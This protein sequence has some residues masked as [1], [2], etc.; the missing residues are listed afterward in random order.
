MNDLFLTFKKQF[1]GTFQVV[2]WLRHR[3][4]KAGSQGLILVR[5]KLSHN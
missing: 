1:A 4:P 5:I 2:Q 3:A